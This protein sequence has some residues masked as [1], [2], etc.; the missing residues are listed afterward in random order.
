M[1]KELESFISAGFKGSNGQEVA[2]KVLPIDGGFL[3]MVKTHAP[4]LSS[5][6]KTNVIA[7]HGEKVV[8]DGK[9]ATIRINAT[10]P[11]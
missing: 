2:G 6:G 7:S 10:L 5:T 1:K 11:L 4:K 9:I 8:Y 3:V